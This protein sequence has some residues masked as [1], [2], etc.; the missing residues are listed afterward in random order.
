MSVLVIL[1]QRYSHDWSQCPVG[2]LAGGIMI[3]DTN[4]RNPCELQRVSLHQHCVQSALVSQAVVQCALASEFTSSWCIA[5]E[6]NL[7]RHRSIVVGQ[8]AQ[9]QGLLLHWHTV[10]GQISSHTHACLCTVVAVCPPKR[11]RQTS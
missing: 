8:V 2:T 11:A 7:Q 3:H 9:T 5:E 1:L 6:Y 4:D 10:Y